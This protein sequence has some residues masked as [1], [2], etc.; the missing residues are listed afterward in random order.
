MLHVVCEL[1]T[2]Q[3]RHES[4]AVH[5]CPPLA[6]ENTVQEGEAEHWLTHDAKEMYPW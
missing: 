1:S 5:L 2:S 3:Q 6:Y 4:G